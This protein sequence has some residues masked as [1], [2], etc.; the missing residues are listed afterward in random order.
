MAEKNKTGE[1]VALLLVIIIVTMLIVILLSFFFGGS[2][3]YRMMGGMFMPFMGFGLL[4]PIIIIFLLVYALSSTTE[5]ER[6]R[7]INPVY[8]NYS[9]FP[10]S[11]EQILDYRLAT[12]QI[13]VDEYKR[14][15]TTLKESK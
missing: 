14:L 2:M 5:S 13:S 7:Y 12:G 3:S 11:A 6:P 9:Q 1:T 4:I 10:S 15:K 8:A